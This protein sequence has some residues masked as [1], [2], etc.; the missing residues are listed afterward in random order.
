MLEMG[1]KFYMQ[2]P[3]MLQMKTFL[4]DFLAWNTRIYDFFLRKMKTELFQL[5]DHRRRF[6]SYKDKKKQT[7]FGFVDTNKIK[8]AETGMRKIA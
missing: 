3:I 5:I 4:R 2:K 8:H 7:W 6:V 1:G